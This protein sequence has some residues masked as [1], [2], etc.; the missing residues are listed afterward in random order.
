MPVELPDPPPRSEGVWVAKPVLARLIR[1]AIFVCPLLCALVATSFA[2]RVLGPPDN[3]GVLFVQWV[4]LLALG[5]GVAIGAERIARRFL[6]L[7]TLLKLSM[8]FPARAPSRFKIARQAGS[9]RQLEAT[10]VIAGDAGETADAG[11]T[12]A[13]ILALVARLSEHD[14]RT[15][16]HS[17]RVRVYTDMI[18][19]ELKLEPADRYRLRWAALLHDIG[20][21]AVSTD[22]LNKSEGLT[23]DEWARMQEHPIEGMRLAGPLVAW[24]GPWAD[25]IAHHH[26]R[27]DGT[28]YPVGL[29][30]DE[31]CAGARIVAVADSYDTMTSVR[32]YRKPVATR[33]AREELVACAG[34]QF[35]PIVVRAFLAISLPRL[36]WATG[37]V[38]LL[39]HLPFLAR[40]QV[41]GEVSVASAAQAIT[42]TA[43]AGVVVVGLMG[44]ANA[45]PARAGVPIERS[46]GAG[47][48]SGGRHGVSGGDVAGQGGGSGHDHGGNDD[49]TLDDG[50]GGSTGDD[51]GGGG[52]GGGITPRPSPH[53]SPEP[54]PSPEPTPSPSPPPERTGVAVPDVVGMRETVAV[55]ALEQAGFVVQSQR[56][57]TDDKTAKNLVIAQSPVAGD[58]L[59]AGSTITITV[60]KWRN[61]T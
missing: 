49:G 33:A 18:A 42:A 43:A 4:V 15:R 10:D 1:F 11:D 8:L 47:D 22:I 60:G 59:P 35:D 17:E 37:P 40:L 52:D 53:P 55:A 39:V 3:D 28:G 13:T 7:A 24:L 25:T 32:S 38:S 48:L 14:K 51:T 36:L 56:Q 45:P 31:I 46:I 23:N 57:W 26:E 54:S 21:L 29:A 30:A 5:V 41:V 27:F 19:E 61:K 20:K 58:T 16:G 12:A 9:V 6:P 34:S 2:R 50:D 44:P